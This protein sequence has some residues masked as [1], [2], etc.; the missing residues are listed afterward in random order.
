MRDRWWEE[1]ERRRNDIEERARERD[2]LVQLRYLER[3]SK[4]SSSS[5]SNVNAN[6]AELNV[7]LEQTRASVAA[8]RASR[9]EK[10]ASIGGGGPARTSASASPPFLERIM[11]E[12]ENE[13]DEKMHDEEIPEDADNDEK[14]CVPDVCVPLTSARSKKNSKTS[15][16]VSSR[17]QS[18]VVDGKVVVAPT[19]SFQSYRT[20]PAKDRSRI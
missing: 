19:S 2:E 20:A 9:A 7:L 6:A 13:A 15:S 1:T 14:A 18:T 5:S 3:V 4:Y 8:N 12:G 10:R 17:R 16:A 11:E